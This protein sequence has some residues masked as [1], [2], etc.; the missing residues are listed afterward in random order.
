[1]LIDCFPAIWQP[2]FPGFQRDLLVLFHIAA[3]FHFVASKCRSVIAS[4]SGKFSRQN[5][6]SDDRHA[7]TLPRDQRGSAGRIANQRHPSIRPTVHAD[8]TYVVEVEVWRIAHF[9]KQPRELPSG[10]FRVPRSVVRKALLPLEMEGRL[11]RHVGR[12]TFVANGEERRAGSKDPVDTSPAELLDACLTCY[13]QMSELAVA[14]ATAADLRAIEQCLE[15]LRDTATLAEYAARDAAFH[16]AIA[17]ATHNALLV[18]IARIIGRAR[19][20]TDWGE[21]ALHEGTPRDHEGILEAL[22][23]RNAKLARE[24]TRAH[25]LHARRSLLRRQ[26]L[27]GHAIGRAKAFCVCKWLVI[28]ASLKGIVS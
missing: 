8:L 6:G 7:R 20:R 3:A 21:L 5:I 17:D 28:G 23:K 14:T 11:T 19:E 24:R 2:N 18:E 27:N 12:G 15:L 22:V 9:L 4:R 10:R 25:L 26:Q 13:P 16:Q 1:L